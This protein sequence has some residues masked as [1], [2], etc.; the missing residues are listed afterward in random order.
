MD[1]TC[2]ICYINK[3]KKNSCNKQYLCEPCVLRL[4]NNIIR[5]KLLYNYNPITNKCDYCNQTRNV[6]HVG[7]CISHG[8]SD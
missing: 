1:H 7:L 2:I 8:G 3:L 5:T 4:S 6:Y